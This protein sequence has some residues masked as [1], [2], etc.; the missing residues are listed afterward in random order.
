MSVATL[1]TRMQ[2]LGDD[3]DWRGLR[4]EIHDEVDKPITD[5]EHHTLLALFTALMDLVERNVVAHSPDKLADFKNT[6]LEDYRLLMVKRAT[7][8]GNVIPEKLHRIT[9]R[10]VAEG[11]MAPDDTLHTLAVAGYEVL[12]PKPSKPGFLSRLFGKS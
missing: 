5:E 3:V 10:E 11:R 4:E 7:V 6:R 2:S 12:T 8:D 1:L 9:A